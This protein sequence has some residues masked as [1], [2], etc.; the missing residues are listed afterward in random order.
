MI[1]VADTSPL[2]YLILLKHPEVLQTLYG[3]VV[4]PRAVAGE[5]KSRKSPEAV[6]RWIQDPPEWLRVLEVVAKRD[7][8]LEKLDDGE[9]EAILLAQELRA[10]A[11]ILDEKARKAG[12]CAAEYSGDWHSPSAR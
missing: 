1:V 9:R 5:L 2:N 10:D 7:P 12:S 11:L 6:R 4:I 3:Q 8:E